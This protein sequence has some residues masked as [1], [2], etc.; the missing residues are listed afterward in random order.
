MN[1][2]VNAFLAVLPVGVLFAIILIAHLAASDRHHPTAECWMLKNGI[3]SAK[4]NGGSIS[5]HR[6]WL[7]TLKNAMATSLL[8]L[9]T[10]LLRKRTV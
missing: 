1:W 8:N 9:R 6:N 3:C 4:P 2:R 5:P 10:K 7:L